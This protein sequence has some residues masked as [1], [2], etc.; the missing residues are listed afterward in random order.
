[1]TVK[2]GVVI[3]ARWLRTGIGRYTLSLLRGLKEHLRNVSL[4]CI[5]QPQHV[6]TVSGF[7]ECVIPCDANIYGLK[8]Q[9]A[10]PWLAK[11]A[12]ALYSPH[13]NIPVVWSRRLLVTIHDLNHLLDAT[14][15]GSWKSRLYAK[16]LLSI[17]ARNA[18]VI[19]TP[20]AYTKT[21]LSEHLDVEPSR[22]SVIP[23]C[24]ASCFQ[25]QDKREARS[26]VARELGITRPYLLFVG[27]CAPNK[28]V[29]LL[30]ESMAQLRRGSDDAP[31]LVIAGSD[32][33]WRPR[34]R[35][36]ARSLGLQE[37]V[38][39]REGITDVFLA[40]LYSAALMTI[41]PSFEEG[42]GLPVIESMACGTPVVCSQA[43]SLPEVAGDAALLFSP[44]SCEQL[45]HN[46]EH[47]IGSTTTQERLIAAG[48]ERSA[49]FSQQRFGELQASAIRELLPN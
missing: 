4:T 6:E 16:P 45:T 32:C 17:A 27:N 15:R 40:Q 10:L 18:D 47:L 9:L 38:V 35:D 48:L 3:D 49:L 37:E 43:A 30:L 46:I 13:Y 22:I 2:G 26:F 44:Y 8:E 19:I 25:K 5:T 29:P 21:M 23:G 11:S 28:N 24:V 42:F 33:K 36:Y 31:L 34:M 1:L 20:S 14:Y 7:C 39:W 41:V 12:A